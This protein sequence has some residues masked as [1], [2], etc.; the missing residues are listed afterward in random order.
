MNRFFVCLA[1]LSIVLSVDTAHG[2]ESRGEPGPAIDNYAEILASLEAGAAQARANRVDSGLPRIM[3]TGYWPPT[4]EIVRHLSDNPAQN[5]TWEGGNWEGRGYDV[6]SFFPE[7][8]AG[9][10]GGCS[11]GKGVGDFEV[12][13]QD[14]SSDWWQKV[15]E[16]N[17]VAILTFSRGSS[18]VKWEIEWVQ[19]NLST[20]SGDYQSPTQPTP[21]PPDGDVEAGFTRC[22]SMPI[23]NIIE[24]VVDAVPGMN[25]YLDV[26]GFGGGF[27]SEFIAYHGVWSRGLHAFPDDPTRVLAGGHIHVGWNTGPQGDCNM[28]LVPLRAALDAT[29]HAL[30]DH[31]DAYPTQVVGDRCPESCMSNPTGVSA[32]QT[33]PTYDVPCSFFDDSCVMG[34]TK[35]VEVSC[36]NLESFPIT[37]HWQLSND[38]VNCAFDEQTDVAFP[39]SD[40]QA[41]EQFGTCGAGGAGDV[42]GTNCGCMDA[43]SLVIGPNGQA[44]VF[45]VEV[46]CPSWSAVD[47]ECPAETC[48]ECM[49]A[50]EDGCAAMSETEALPGDSA[51]LRLDWY[52]TNNNT[53]TRS[54]RSFV[55]AGMSLSSGNIA[56]PPLANDVFD[57][58]GAVKAC[59]TDADCAAGEPGAAPQTVCRDGSCYVARNRFLSVRANPGNAGTS[60]AYRIGLDT[61]S[62]GMVTLGFV[63]APQVVNAFGPGPSVFHLARIDESPVYRDWEDVVTIGDCEVSPGHS[64]IVQALV[65]GEDPGDEALYSAPLLLPTVANHGDVTGGGAVGAPP[66]GNTSLGD[67]FAVILGF[68]NIQHEPKDWLDLDPNGGPAAPNLLVSLADT[69]AAIQGFQLQPYPGPEPEDCP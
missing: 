1:A 68:Q 35:T 47:Y 25:A 42:A 23:Q 21:S 56:E 46:A 7:F 11:W 4:N 22:S 49:Q 27:L 5:P 67:A 40:L 9:P 10:T 57:V 60:Y 59:V 3:V 32:F 69:F 45:E 38:N 65:M 30:I 34:E 37:L 19:R 41:C 44:G 26:D 16:I 55:V 6:Y 14:T 24:A 2:Q 12:D 53:S 8:P 61:S 66:D 15:A 36:R 28:D 64:Y 33:P 17:P 39:T 29:L 48:C 58:T 20:W 43:G 51:C 50:W 18:G 13:Y 63:Q 62:A 54:R 31:L 52:A